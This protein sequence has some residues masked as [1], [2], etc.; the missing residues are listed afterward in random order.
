MTDLQLESAVMDNCALVSST[1]TDEI[2]CLMVG[3]TGVRDYDTEC[4]RVIDNCYDNFI[5]F[6]K[7]IPTF[8]ELESS[9]MDDYINRQYAICSLEVA[10]EYDCSQLSV[11]E[12]NSLVEE[13][14]T[15]N[16]DSD[17][18]GGYLRYDEMIACHY[19][20]ADTTNG[21][22]QLTDSGMDFD[23]DNYV[24]YTK[25]IKEAHDISQLIQNIYDSGA[26]EE[27]IIGDCQQVLI[28]ELINNNCY[29]NS[30]R[31]LCLV[32]DRR[33]KTMLSGGNQNAIRSS[34]MSI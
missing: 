18:Y 8:S 27:V 33:L 21:V 4:E 1:D 10:E 2:A 12:F 3:F 17:S 22:V 13:R 23:I 5:E 30:Y 28:P 15:S 29:T 20:I 31:E 25:N 16:M 9:I 7:R 14:A 26:F 24:S 32:G 6:H 34:K 19:D 11:A